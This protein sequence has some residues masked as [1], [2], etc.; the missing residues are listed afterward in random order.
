M[1]HGYLIEAEYESGYVLREDANDHS[2]YDPGKNTFNAIL[3]HRPTDAGHGVLVRL[4][5]VPDPLDGRQR[6]DIAWEA[7]GLNALGARPVCYRK[8]ERDDKVDGSGNIVSE[9]EVRCMSHHFG[10]QYT[11]PETG[12]NVQEVVDLALGV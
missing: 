12:R 6:Y 4:S 8:M 9:G 11:D 5:Y 3:N 2:P 1:A 7:H 10:Y